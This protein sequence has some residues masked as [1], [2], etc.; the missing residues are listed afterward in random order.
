MPRSLVYRHVNVFS[1]RPLS[2]NGL[3]V[4]LDGRGLDTTVMQAIAREMNL[5]ETSFV[6]PPKSRQATY[7]IRTFTPTQEVSFAGHA[8][9]GTAF[10]LAR[11]GLLPLY[12]PLTAL[13]QENDLGVTLL[14]VEVEGGRPTRVTLTVPSP[15]FGRV[16]GRPG[17][18]V[19][20]ALA[21]ALGVE[22]DRMTAKGLFPQIVTIGG[23]AHLVVCLDELTSVTATVPDP[24]ALGRIG[25]QL[26]VSGFAVFARGALDPRAQFHL[27]FFAPGSSAVEDAGTSSAA[28]AVGAFL[29]H[30]RAAQPEPAGPL[31]FTIEQGVE[32]RRTS[33][34]EV[35]ITVDSLELEAYTVRVSGRCVTVASGEL[36]LP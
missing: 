21:L 1:D 13:W 15:V 35:A 32:L 12:E 25:Q 36:Y 19:L 24:A 16:F 8:F 6:F 27:R 18:P 11:D 28:A 5:S 14:E 31:R 4:F 22:P 2:G 30:R 20:S 9:H 26:E 29:A 10:V 23:I 3:T 7:F 17:S 33:L 34:L